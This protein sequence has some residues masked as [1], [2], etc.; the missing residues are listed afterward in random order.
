[1]NSGMNNPM[2]SHQPPRLSVIIPTYNRAATLARCL[3]ALGAQS[4]APE[5]FE[6]IVADDGSSDHSAE[7][8]ATWAAKLPCALRWL[9]QPNAGA[10]RARNR[11]IGMARGE[12]LL[13]INDDT[14]AVPQMLAEHL[15]THRQY[16]DDCVAVL[17]RMT[18]SPDVPHSRLAPLHLDRA[19]VGLQGGAEL[20]W[21][22]FFTC[23][24]SLKKTLLER[25]G[26]FEERIRYHEDLELAWRLSAQGLRVVYRP[27]AL[28]WHEHCLQEDEFLAIAEREARALCTWWQISPAAR[29]VLA[30]LG[31]EPALPWVRRARHRVF[32]LLL[33]RTAEPLW[34]RLA[35]GLPDRFNHASLALYDQLYQSRKRAAL[36]ALL[37][38]Q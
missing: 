8:V 13:L 26:L 3:A 22:A 38:P 7:V 18:V 5:D 23:N 9:H 20:D 10:N 37:K 24:V 11:A 12:L 16:P 6:I 1:M 29:P 31:Y 27:Q 2:T 35:R 32:D 25:G 33:S 34:R 15:A 36:R 21:R 4:C 14:I 28:G 19:F 17:G 30:S